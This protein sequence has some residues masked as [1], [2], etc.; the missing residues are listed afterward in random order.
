[1][2]LQEVG[3]FGFVDRLSQRV[4]AHHGVQLGIGDDCAVTD[5]PV[6][7]R[8]LTTTDLLV[9]GIHFDLSYT[10]PASLGYK[11]LAVNLSDIAA[12]GGVPRHVL[13]GLAVPPT[14]DVEFLDAFTDSFIALADQH[15]VTLIGGDTCA[16]L[17]GLMVSVTLV[18][19]QV[20]DR[21]L[22]RGAAQPGDLIVVSGTVGDSALGLE[23][24]QG[25]LLTVDDAEAVRFC[26]NRHLRPMPRVALGQLLANT[27]MVRAMIDLSDGIL[28]DLG[29]I[30]TASNVG[31][32]L[33][34]AQLPISSAYRTLAARTL[35][36][37]SELALTGGEDYELLF[38]IPQEREADLLRIQASAEVPLTVI[39]SITAETE[40]QILDSAGRAL[41]FPRSGY[42]HFA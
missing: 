17:A 42:N 33:E 30:L 36:N 14:I 9:E 39:G 5:A 34:A 35:G 23:L 22:T 18:G 3:E 31:A 32:S 13:L 37:F 19:E 29:H 2:R 28:A 38:T 4:V 8:T 27:G 41:Q 40:L 21:I 7:G 1:M 25:R 11:S 20:P 10:D 16:S 26:I 12:M 15:A 6:S 24:L